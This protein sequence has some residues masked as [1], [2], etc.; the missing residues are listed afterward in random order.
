MSQS[1]F[2]QVSLFFPC[3]L[4]VG[5]LIIFSLVYKEGLEFILKN[6]T[7]A[8]RVL[9]PYL[10]FTVL[11]WKIADRKSYTALVLLACVVPVL[12][13]VFFTSFYAVLTCIK[14]HVMDQWYVLCIMGFWATLVA[15]LAEIIPFLILIIFKNDLKCPAEGPLK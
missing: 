1:R 15:Y 2:F 8:Y 4:W 6:F 11:I 14:D 7:Q 10:I 5:A 13:G 12:W 3:V 9:A